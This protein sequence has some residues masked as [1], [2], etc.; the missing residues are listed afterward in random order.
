LEVV[1][2]PVFINIADTYYN[3]KVRLL[4]LCLKIAGSFVI[5][6]LLAFSALIVWLSLNEYKPAALEQVSLTGSAA[7]LVPLG[8]SLELYSWNIG[9]AALDAAQ[10]FFMDGGKGVRPASPA[11]V[12]ENLW[13]IQSFLAG[14][15]ADFVFLQE[16]DRDSLRSWGVDEAGYLAEN[17][18]GSAVYV[19]NYRCPFVPYPFF[20]FTGQVESGL[21]TLNTFG[22]APRAERVALPGTFDWP[23][24]LAQ[25]KRCLLVERLP[26]QD[27]ELVLVNLHLEAYD[28]GNGREEQTRVLVEFLLS[29]YAKGNYCVAGGDFNQ[30]FPGAEEQFP[31]KNE[32]A[33]FVPGVFDLS[34]MEGWTLAADTSA[35]SA[36]LLDKPYNGRREE[37]QFY[38]IDGFLVSPNITVESVQT[39]DLDFKN[40]DHNPVKLTFSL[41]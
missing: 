17:W 4:V 3:E 7:A 39:I 33:G 25:L 26:V 8:Q 16:V 30:S 13:A 34:L 19:S 11:V 35:P 22:A 9:Y 24:R 6:A 41:K 32:N 38:V 27:A 15:A 36:R 18:K 1:L 31:L 5:L 28:S 2:P 21:V 29:E 23:L 37:H 12:E 14:S 40:S 20:R 10:D